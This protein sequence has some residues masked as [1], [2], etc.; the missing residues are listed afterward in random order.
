MKKDS[1]LDT[2]WLSKAHCKGAGVDMFFIDE[3]DRES[4]K[5]LKAAKTICKKCPVTKQ[6]L[7][8]ALQAP[9]E[10]GVWGGLSPSERWHIRLQRKAPLGKPRGT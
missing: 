3:R 1:E 10:F 5:R 8:Y 6:C 2:G 9:M 7:E 4:L